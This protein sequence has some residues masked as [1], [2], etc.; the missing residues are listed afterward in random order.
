M[1][2]F[3]AIASIEEAELYLQDP[4]LRSRL[5]TATTAVA[6]R[7]RQKVSLDDLMGSAIDAAKLVSCLTLFGAVARRLSLAGETG[8][9]G[10]LA[11]FADEILAAAAGEGHP[12]CRYTMER[13]TAGDRTSR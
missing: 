13:L 3:Y 1:S 2:R 8:E 4:S 10:S 12:P 11:G 7:L 9:Y 5:L 6:E